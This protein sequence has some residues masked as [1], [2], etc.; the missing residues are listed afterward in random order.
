MSYYFLKYFYR[1]HFVWKYFLKFN[2]TMQFSLFGFC[3]IIKFSCY[4]FIF[5]IFLF[6]YLF[7][8]YPKINFIL[9]AISLLIFF[10]LFE[11]FF[12]IFFFHRFWRVNDDFFVGNAFRITFLNLWKVAIKIHVLQKT[13]VNFSQVFY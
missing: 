4:R 6:A 9:I 1:H 8:Q 11:F 13:I 10:Y 5:Y 7:V 3:L 12:R 2:L